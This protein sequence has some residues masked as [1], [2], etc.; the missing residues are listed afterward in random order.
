MA[1]QTSRGRSSNPIPS[2]T[3]RQRALVESQ[4]V[5]LQQAPSWHGALPVLVLDR[6]WMR[7]T[8]L[9]LDALL[10]KLP[11]DSTLEAPE[12]VDYRRLIAAGVPAW[13]AEQ[14]GW[15]AFGIEACH[16][17]LQ[18]FWAMQE[19]GNQG[20]SAAAYFDLL[21]EYRRRFERQNPRPL[22][23]LVLARGGEHQGRE[24]HQLHWLGPLGQEAER[25]MRH[26]CA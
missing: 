25:S 3:L 26:T 10:L 17:A 5:L 18:R 1:E 2:L 6:C 9:D 24:A 15:Q 7:L 13:Q 20:W 12:L 11:P 8:V 23:L 22:P 14:L 19:R 4:L 21:H 16:Q